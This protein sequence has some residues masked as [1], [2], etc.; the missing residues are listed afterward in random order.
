M[1]RRLRSTTWLLAACSAIVVFIAPASVSAHATLDGSSPVANAVVPSAPGEISLDFSEAIEERLA[2]IRLFDGDEREITIE[3][4]RRL[5]SDPS[6]VVS[7]LPPIAAGVYVV[8]WRV[9]SADGHPLRGS[10]SFEVGNTTVG[11]TTE[12]VETVV[13]GL[14][15]D[16]SVGVPLGVSRFAAYLG[17]VLLVGALVVTW[18]STRNVLSSPRGARVLSVGLA[19]LTLGTLG[20]LFLQGPH[21]TGGDF[22]DVFDSTLVA[23]VASTRLGVALLARLGFILAWVVVLVGAMRGLAS[24]GAWRSSAV[25]AAI[26]TIVTFPAAGH[27]SAL[28]V[29]AAHVALGAV[30]VAALS[31]W[32][33][34]LAVT[35]ALRRDDDGIV[36]RLSRV[37]TWAMPIAVLSG[38][39]LAVRLTGGLEDIFDTNYGRVLAIKTV[40]VVLVVIGAATARQRTRSGRDI[41]PSLRFET[42]VAV[43]VLA[44]TAGLTAASPTAIAPPPVW[45]ASLV[46][47]GVML[48]VSVSPAR[49]GSAEVHVIVAPPGGALAPVKDASATI[50][51]PSRDIPPSPVDL[52]LVG[53]NHYVGIIQIPY[54]GDWTMA[55]TATGSKGESLV[56]SGEFTVDD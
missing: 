4:A 15:D 49:V 41:V 16:S 20:V 40:L 24:T 27:P 17:V 5:A 6:I 18:R 10:Y 48:E 53:P 2:S 25:V 46:A 12:L 37:A 43:A 28:P 19:A 54:A 56:W 21:V 42:L 30:H 7:N 1:K 9:V 32:I 44:V 13:R 31:A 45:T 34:S 29:A 38:V 47:E 33:G 52:V 50:A 36:A 35:Y 39:A 8:V 51:L 26:G 55:I 3:R 22:G 11:D 14:D 23:D